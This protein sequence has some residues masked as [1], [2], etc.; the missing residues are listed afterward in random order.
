MKIKAYIE[1]DEKRNIRKYRE[2][3]IVKMLPT[4]NIHLIESVQIDCENNKNCY[5]YDYFKVQVFDQESYDYDERENQ[6]TCESDYI[7]I[8]YYAILRV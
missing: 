1:M 4:E 7:D 8:F 3:E 6:V 2:F 5:D